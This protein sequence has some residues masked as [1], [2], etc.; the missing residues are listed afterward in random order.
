MIF[1]LWLEFVSYFRLPVSVNILLHN[2]LRRELQLNDT[3]TGNEASVLDSKSFILDQTDPV[4]SCLK[5]SFFRWFHRMEI[6]AQMFFGQSWSMLASAVPWWS[7][8]YQPQSGKFPPTPEQIWDVQH[9][10]QPWSRRAAPLLT[11]YH[12]HPRTL[13]RHSTLSPLTLLLQTPRWTE[14]GTQRRSKGLS[15]K[16]PG[17]RNVWEKFSP[18]TSRCSWAAGRRE[19]RWRRSRRG[20]WGRTGCWTRR[21]RT[22]LWEETSRDGTRTWKMETRTQTEAGHIPVKKKQTKTVTQRQTALASK[23]GEETQRMSRKPVWILPGDTEADRAQ[24]GQDVVEQVVAA[25]S[26]LQ[27]DVDLGELQLDVV[28]VVQ[29]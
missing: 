15:W 14:G 18:R 3:I 9:P 5:A 16:R 23:A 4:I 26:G 29:E 7:L 19:E 21:W 13:W 20:C 10:H 27:V 2:H 6:S 17:D 24:V 11:C 8:F 28:D 25:S 22:A 12:P 1:F